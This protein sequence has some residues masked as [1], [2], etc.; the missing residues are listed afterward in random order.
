MKAISLEHDFI[1]LNMWHSVA[2]KKKKSF[3]K[4]SEIFSM[5]IFLALF[6][7]LNVILSSQSST[8]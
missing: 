3:Q 8:N 7:I 5:H 6:Q 1:L 2:S 4:F